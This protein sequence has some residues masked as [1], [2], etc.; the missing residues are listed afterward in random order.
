MVTVAG[1][2]PGN[3]KY[4]TVEVKEAIEKAEYVLA[5]GR[6]SNSLKGIRDDV[7]QVNKVGDIINHTNIHNDLLYL[8]THGIQF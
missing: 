4:L 8:H 3:P 1:V 2:G 7:I 6:V 5:F